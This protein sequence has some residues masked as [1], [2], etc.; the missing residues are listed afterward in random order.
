[1]VFLMG[2]LKFDCDDFITIG[3]KHNGLKLYWNPKK[4][5]NKNVTNTA[6]TI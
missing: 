5:G 4:K 3:I 1:M 6:H 2:F